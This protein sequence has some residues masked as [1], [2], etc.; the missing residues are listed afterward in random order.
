MTM[1][2]L[3][4][5]MHFICLWPPNDKTEEN[6]SLKSEALGRFGVISPTLKKGESLPSH[7]QKRL[8]RLVYS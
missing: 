7:A 1:V 6:C 3:S 2:T 5:G 4:M 8:S